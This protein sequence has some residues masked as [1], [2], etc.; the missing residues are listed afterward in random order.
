LRLHLEKKK[1]MAINCGRL[2][3]QAGRRALRYIIAIIISYL[4]ESDHEGAAYLQADETK[5]AIR[6]AL[7]EMKQYPTHGI[8]E[9]LA[10]MLI[11]PPRFVYNP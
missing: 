6:P 9:E 4:N 5:A 7:F 10:F 1:E 3:L 11:R 8:M 2:V